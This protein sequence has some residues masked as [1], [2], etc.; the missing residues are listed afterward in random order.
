MLIV[1]SLL[2]V[3]FLPR[4]FVGQERLLA[5]LSGVGAQARALRIRLHRDEVLAVRRM[6]CFLFL[7]LVLTWGV[8]VPMGRVVRV[9]RVV[10]VGV[11]RLGVALA[12]WA[13]AAIARLARPSFTRLTRFTHFMRLVTAQSLGTIEFLLWA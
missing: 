7:A 4:G 13:L 5:L 6:A 2:C 11:G 3:G 12:Y 1:P 9:V 10:R 8:Q